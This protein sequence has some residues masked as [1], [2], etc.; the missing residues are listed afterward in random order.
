MNTLI[1]AHIEKMNRLVG[2]SKERR[3]AELDF[4]TEASNKYRSFLNNPLAENPYKDE[5]LQEIVVQDFIN[6]AQ[7]S[8]DGVIAKQTRLN[9]NL[10]NMTQ[11]EIKADKKFIA[12]YFERLDKIAKLGGYLVSAIDP[13]RP[14][15]LPEF[16]QNY[17][18]I[19]INGTNERIKDRNMFMLAGWASLFDY[20]EDI[21][22]IKDYYF[23]KTTV[24]EEIGILTQRILIL[25][26]GETF[27]KYLHNKPYIV[28]DILENKNLVYGEDKKVYYEIKGEVDSQQL[29][30]NDILTLYLS[31]VPKHMNLQETFENAGIT[32]NATLQPQYFLGGSILTSTDEDVSQDTSIKIPIF[33]VNENKVIRYFIKPI[34]TEAINLTPAYKSEIIAYIAGL[35]SIASGNISVLSGYSNKRL[36]MDLPL[37]INEA[38]TSQI[39]R[40]Y[41]SLSPEGK[42]GFIGNR[43]AFNT[44]GQG[45][46]KKVSLVDAQKAYIM[47]IIQDHNLAVKLVQEAMPGG[48]SMVRETLTDETPQGRDIIK[49]LNENNMPI[50]EFY[51]NMLGI[52]EWQAGMVLFYQKLPEEIKDLPEEQDED[53]TTFVEQYS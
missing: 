49:V 3:T 52:K 44:I 27:K 18:N 6:I 51:K 40:L 5:S 1:K 9:I 19:N 23:K 33:Y 11:E 2:V 30:N 38:I 13:V 16:I 42:A 35:F 45:S 17:N 39:E 29:T 34:D 10:K 36:G 26:T 4:F 32:V 21:K 15:N 37:G 48:P 20:F 25:I 14:Q 8:L 7:H 41:Y 12:T 47:S 28:G 46:K 22:V 53:V 24:A 31:Q 50:P 43:Y